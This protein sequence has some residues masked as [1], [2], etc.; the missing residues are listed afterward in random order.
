MDIF[1]ESSALAKVDGNRELMLEL[2]GMMISEL[3]RNI[4]GLE[5]AFAAGSKEEQW[6][7]AHKI[8]GSTAYCGVPALQQCARALEDSIKNDLDDIQS[9]FIDIKREVDNITD[10][11]QEHFS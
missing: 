8:Y 5:S 2:L 1:D 3:P 11:Y 9:R 4:A 7:I 10:Y 6:N